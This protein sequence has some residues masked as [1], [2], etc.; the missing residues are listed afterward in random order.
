[1]ATSF[2]SD[3]ITYVTS[4]KWVKRQ[5]LSIFL[6]GSH[7][8]FDNYSCI[9]SE[10]TIK[11]SKADLKLVF[12]HSVVQYQTRSLQ[13]GKQVLWALCKKAEISVPQE[14]SYHIRSCHIY[15]TDCYSHCTVGQCRS[16]EAVLSFG[17]R[18]RNIPLLAQFFVFFFPQARWYRAGEENWDA[19]KI[20]P[21]SDFSDYYVAPKFST[22]SCIKI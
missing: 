20:N 16:W 13:S 17:G 12:L 6:P 9:V 21:A 15:N 19:W 5:F 2:E 11:D 18:M 3:E 22:S 14:I 8:G 10:R 7:L 4:W 1:M